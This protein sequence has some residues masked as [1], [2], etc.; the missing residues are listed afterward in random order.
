MRH[1]KPCLTLITLILLTSFSLSQATDQVNSLP[2]Q[3]EKPTSAQAAGIAGKSPTDSPGHD[4]FAARV[5]ARRARAG[6]M[7]SLTPDQRLSR[8]R[9]RL[10]V[11]DQGAALGLSPREIPT[12]VETPEAV[13][14]FARLRQMCRNDL[15]VAWRNDTRTPRFLAGTDLMRNKSGGAPTPQYLAADFLREYRHLLKIVDPDHEF[16]LSRIETSRDGWQAVRF[17]QRYVDVEVWG[18]DIV[19]RLDPQGRVIGFSGNYR[20]TPTEQSLVP[21]VGRTDAC[22]EAVTQLGSRDRVSPIAEAAEL[23]LYPSRDELHLAW[24]VLVTA[25]ALYRQEVFIDANRGRMIHAV[26]LVMTDGAVVGSGNDLSGTPRDLGLWQIGANYYMIDT[27]KD[28]FDAGASTMPDDARGAIWLIDANHGEGDNAFHVTSSSPSSWGGYANAVSVQTWA[29]HFYDYMQTVHGR[30][31]FD[32]EGKTVPALINVGTNLNNA[33]WNGQMVFFGNGDGSTFGDLAGAMDIACH[34]LGHAVISYTANLVYEFQPGAL[35]EA[36]ADIFGASTEFFALGGGGNWQMAEDVTTPGTPGDCLRDLGDPNGAHVYDPL[37]P[38]MDQF[39]DMPASQDHG[40]VHVNCS[41]PTRAYYLHAEDIGLDKAERV[42]Y[43]TL[44]NYLNRNS[45]FIDLRLGAI[46]AAADLYGD[47]SPEQLSV[48]AAMDAVGIIDGQSTEDPPDLPDNLGTDYI[49]VKECGTDHYWALSPDL[50]EAVDITGMAVGPAGRP[51]FTDDGS[52]YA[53]VGEDGDIYLLETTGS[54]GYQLTDTGEWWSVALSPNGLLLAAT[55]AE[56]DGRIYLFDLVEPANSVYYELT[57]QDDTGEASSALVL[58]AEI[59]DFNLGTGMLVYDAFNQ[60][61]IAGNPYEYWD[62]NLLRLS[63]GTCF[64]VFNPLPPGENIG[65]PTLSQNNNQIMAFDYADA[66][67]G[68]VYVMGCNINS[69]ALGIITYNYQSLGTPS[70]FGDDNT[71]LYQ[72]V[73]ESGGCDY[74]QVWTV[75]LESDRITGA[76]DDTGWTSGAFWPVCFTIGDRPQ[77]T[78]LAAFTGQWTGTEIQ[79]EWRLNYSDGLYGFDIERATSEQGPFR[80]RNSLPVLLA[81][82]DDGGHRFSYRDALPDDGGPVYYRLVALEVSGERHP[83]GTIELEAG[84]QTL[85]SRPVLLPVYPNPANPHVV[86][87]F[88][89]PQ[90]MAGEPSSLTILD[91][92]GQR[93]ATLVAGEGLVAGYHER[94]WHG[95]DDGG[96]AMASGLYFAQLKTRE[97]AITRK[98]MMVR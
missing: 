8:V 13:A 9:Q 6:E 18:R 95:T 35:N 83:L 66:N 3:F 71:L 47:D 52:W 27:R 84:S 86:L 2:I 34:E 58:G 15:A 40:G 68:E 54:G 45:Q 42:W 17:Q 72:Y 1:W 5:T 32:G 73:E 60:M 48:I 10:L 44:T 53:F 29:G 19:V 14:D 59:M 62:I 39:Q 75:S 7:R 97:G 89:V 36:F 51:S 74:H 76:G 64:R 81:E 20:P 57:V 16:L 78:Q 80:V 46:Q 38:H 30:T 28:M 11:L 25:G 67:A 65:N 55:P 88:Y 93:V 21:V 79:L 96:Q 87:K 98:V 49:A 90:N 4:P 24:K 12:F 92:R 85:P 61:E 22:G 50:S 82:G 31:S 26:S 41:I 69:G 91:V 43:R 33:Y 63:D 37:P 70:F 94:I 77:S 56:Y 23:V